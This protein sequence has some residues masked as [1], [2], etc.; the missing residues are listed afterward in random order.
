MLASSSASGELKL[1]I[2]RAFDQSKDVLTFYVS[3]TAKTDEIRERSLVATSIAGWGVGTISIPE[4]SDPL[5]GE[6]LISDTVVFAPGIPFNGYHESLTAFVDEME[7]VIRERKAGAQGLTLYVFVNT[8][9]STEEGAMSE[10][11]I[12]TLFLVEDPEVSDDVELSWW[13]DLY[14]HPQDEIYKLG[15]VVLGTEYR[16]NRRDEECVWSEGYQ[17]DP[18][19][20]R[21]KLTFPFDKECFGM[22]IE[23]DGGVI[24]LKSQSFG[25]YKIWIKGDDIPDTTV[26]LPLDATVEDI[27]DKAGLYGGKLLYKSDRGL[28]DRQRLS[29]IPLQP[30][31]IVRYNPEYHESIV[32]FYEKM[33]GFISQRPSKARGLTLFVWLEVKPHTKITAISMLK[34]V[35]DGNDAPE[36]EMPTRLR[37]GFGHLVWSD[38]LYSRIKTEFFP[39]ETKC[40]GLV[41]QNGE[42]INGGIMALKPWEYVHRERQNR[43][44]QSSPQDQLPYY[45]VLG[46]RSTAT[47]REITRAYRRL[48]LQYHPDKNVDQPQIYGDLFQQLNQAYEVLSDPEK[49]ERYDREN[50]G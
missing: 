40:Y 13:K 8:E 21:L 41:R 49:R 11:A 50:R 31:S 5:T 34:L 47:E 3:S 27:R 7:Y 12:S 24:A 6:A 36:L 45:R 46:V 19:F 9:E 35:E 23:Q 10:V 4:L 26:I 29:D 39:E 38:S 42:F 20:N 15:R 2:K 28:D 33:I 43:V 30:D 37:P 48:A 44:P 14:F 32:D 17:N 25:H 16:L 18:L 22:N 1:Y